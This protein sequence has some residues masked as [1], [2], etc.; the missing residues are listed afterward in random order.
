M[1]DNIK[2]FASNTATGILGGKT[3]SP[4]KD[5]TKDAQKIAPN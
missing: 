1:G 4:I 5:A 3:G 2:K